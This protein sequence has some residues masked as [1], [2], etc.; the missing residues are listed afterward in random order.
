MNTVDLIT[1]GRA[2]MDLY[3]QQ[4][5][6]PFE[7]VRGFDAMVGGS[8]TNIA[9][10]AA[11]LGKRVIAFTGVGDDRVGDFVL[12]YLQDEGVDTS[13]IPRIENKLTSLAL[14]GV[15]PPDH[16]PLSF[17]RTDPADIYLTSAL[18]AE[19]P[20][21]NA[22]ALQLS[23]DA[24]S[25]GTTA[26]TSLSLADGTIS[27]SGTTYLDLDLRPSNWETP[28]DYGEAMRT[29]LAGVDVVF[30]TEEECYAALS[31]DSEAGSRREGLSDTQL[32]TVVDLLETLRADHPALTVVLKRG[33]AGATVISPEGELEVPGFPVPVLNT[34]GAGDSFAAGTI[35]RRLD[36]ADWFEAVRFGNACG[37]IVVTRHGCASALPRPEEVEEFV[38]ANGGW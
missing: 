17:Y 37:A 7:E 38:A 18:A 32:A 15:Q 27:Y 3:S 36:G 33:S 31:P 8:P 10:G 26:A 21:D 28:R 29:A 12:R 22:A 13:F 4:I 5:G 9:I 1:V 11:R 23:G 30:G 16:F 34:V 2:N 14:L 25:R 20:L 6:A 35:S 19:L 24:F